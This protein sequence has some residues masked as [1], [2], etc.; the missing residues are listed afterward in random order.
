MEKSTSKPDR[1]KKKTAGLA[2]RLFEYITFVNQPLKQ[3]FALFAAGTLWWFLVIFAISMASLVSLEYKSNRVVSYLI[4]QDRISQ[5]IV[6][7]LQD[8]RIDGRELAATADQKEAMRI[9]GASREEFQDIN[10]FLYGLVHGGEVNDYSR[11]EDRLIET[12]AVKPALPGD[13]VFVNGIAAKVDEASAG[14]ARLSKL[15][16]AP[17]DAEKDG[18]IAATFKGYNAAL[19][20]AV[21]LADGYSARIS[22]AYAADSGKMRSDLV[23]S[24]PALIVALL[25]ATALLA[26]F[27]FSISRAIIKPVKAMIRQIRALNKG[28]ID[29]GN[30]IKITTQDEIGRLSAEFNGLMDTIDSMNKFKKVIEEDENLEDVYSRLGNE[31]RYFGLE[32]YVIYEVSNSQ[33]KMKAV[34][35]LAGLGEEISCNADIFDNCYLCRAKKTGHKVSSF[36]YPGICRYFLAGERKEHICIPLMVGGTAGGVVQFTF[37]KSDLNSYRLSA[38]EG[39]THAAEQYIK[40]SIPVIEAKRL[41]NTLRDSALKDSLTGL[42]NRRFLQEYTEK[43]VAGT[44]R[45]GK[46]IGLIMGDLDFFKQVNDVYGHNT[47]DALLKETAD[48][49]KKSVRAADL[50]IRFGGEEFLIVLIDVAPDDSLKIAEKIRQTMENTKLKVSDGTLKKTISLGVSEFPGDT[51]SFWQAIKFADVALYEAK[52]TGRNKS[53]R[54]TKEMWKDEQF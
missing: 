46:S 38:I 3:K 1:P 7:K 31:F 10:S 34:Y 11:T 17:P 12:L 40:E 47:G 44:L 42:N 24:F 5:K 41:M 32:E 28:E 49:L 30:R 33:N 19:L 50:V 27:T 54:F 23:C 52:R 4:P 15:K 8:L 14:L 45:R 21:A 13:Q 6:R 36:Q 53:V 2:K 35:P 43:L 51:E 37:D 9:T 29:I 16:L 39:W 18:D 25:L 22:M 26:V 48:I 20:N